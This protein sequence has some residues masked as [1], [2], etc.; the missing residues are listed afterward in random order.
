M[1]CKNCGGDLRYDPASYGLV[2]DYCGFRKMLH[3][4]SEQVVVEELDMSTASRNANMNWGILRRAVTCKYCSA[5]TLYDPEQISGACPYCGSKVVLTP[6]QTNTGMAPNGVIPFSITKEQAAANYYKWNKW[7]LWAPEEFR[8]GKVLGNLTG[9]Y[10]PYWTFDADTITTYEGKFGY[11]TESGDN[12]Y[13]KYYKKSGVVSVF[14]DDYTT[15]GSRRFINDKMFNT[16]ATFNAKDIIPYTPEALLGFAAEK[17]TIDLGEAWNISKA[18]MRKRFE[19]EACRNERADCYDKLQMSTEFTNIK[20]R[21]VLVPMWLTAA[22]YKGKVYNVAI[23]GYNG[24]GNCKRPV[25]TVKIVLLCV[26][27]GGFFFL[28]PILGMLLTLIMSLIQ[29]LFQ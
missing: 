16:I 8:K 25:S 5:V 20:Y 13:T 9:V 21:Y 18:K 6:E 12:S 17:Y 15:C 7:A 2:C 28:V 14:I 4:P 27:V 10:V 24:R 29:Q 1:K 11:T 23:S 19:N 3:R 22:N 26:I